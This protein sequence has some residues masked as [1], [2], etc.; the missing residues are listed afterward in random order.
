MPGVDYKQRLLDET[1]G[2]SNQ[3][4]EKIYRIV[5]V[6][7]EEFLEED[8]ARYRT[9]SCTESEARVPARQGD[10]H[11]NQDPG[12]PPGIRRPHMLA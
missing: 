8:E 11:H 4:W 10:L 9:A 12:D 5:S 7:R 1:V 3:D 2:L 6:I